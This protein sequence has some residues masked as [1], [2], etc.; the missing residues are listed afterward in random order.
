MNILKNPLKCHSVA[1]GYTGFFMQ[2]SPLPPV[3]Q[4]DNT[5]VG[6]NDKKTWNKGKVGL[7]GEFRIFGDCQTLLRKSHRT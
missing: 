5:A 1:Y 2:I 4:N 7:S 6:R 3:G